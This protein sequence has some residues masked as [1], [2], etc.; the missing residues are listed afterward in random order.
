MNYAI[1]YIPPAAFLKFL[2]LERLT[3]IVFGFT[4]FNL[5]IAFTIVSLLADPPFSSIILIISSLTVPLT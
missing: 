5:L 3:I 2:V 1:L 4:V